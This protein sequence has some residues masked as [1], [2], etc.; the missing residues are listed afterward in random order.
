M[1]SPSLYSRPALFSFAGRA[2]GARR[3]R[4]KAHATRAPVKVAV[5]KNSGSKVSALLSLVVTAVG[6]PQRNTDAANVLLV[7]T[8]ILSHLMS[9]SPLSKGSFYVETSSGREFPA[10]FDNGR[11]VVDD[12]KCGT[13][14]E[15]PKCPC[16]SARETNRRAGAKDRP[17]EGGRSA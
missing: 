13:E 1:R 17:P 5:C 9:E 2:R 4:P 15:A 6:I 12:S 10:K 16:C 8:S 3:R 7:K 14:P 11:F